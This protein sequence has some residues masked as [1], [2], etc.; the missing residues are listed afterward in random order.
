M[1]LPTPSP[2]TNRQVPDHAILDYYNKQVY[3]GNQ[4][5]YSQS[6]ETVAATSETPI[7]LISNPATSGKALFITYR[8]G[9]SL[10]ASSSV[11]FRYYFN[12]T[13]TG[14]GTAKTPL[15]LRPANP[16]LSI[17]TVGKD[18]T[19][20]SNG[21][22]VSSFISAA[23]TSNSSILMAVVDP[24]STFLLTATPSVNPTNIEHEIVWYE[25]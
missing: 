5:I 15:N 7:A 3:L 21:T 14:A 1:A 23:L 24:G 20:S 19:T 16:N 13:V 4:F 11:I 12:P 10:T 9:S 18:P 8:A 25:I 17:A 6:S 2:A 22:F